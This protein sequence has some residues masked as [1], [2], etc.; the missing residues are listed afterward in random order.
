M[1]LVF[2]TNNIH[3]IREIKAA[4]GARYNLLSLENSNIFGEIPEEEETLDGNALFKAR[5]VYKRTG[6]AVFAD[7]T[8]LEVEALDNK[9]G[10]HS[11]RYAGIEKD[12][13]ANISRLLKELDGQLNRSARFRTVIA[14]IY[15]DN[16]ILFDGIVTGKITAERRGTGGFG[17][18]PVFLPEGYDSTFAEMELKEKNLI[19]HRAKAIRKL[20]SFFE[21]QQV[22]YF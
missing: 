3:K 6:M 17:Y 19:S 11:A 8:G 2:A 13:D 9:P 16:E 1:D 18:D 15:N 10:V 20:S 4:L 21:Q 14:L 22:Q 7:D 5:Y 12:S